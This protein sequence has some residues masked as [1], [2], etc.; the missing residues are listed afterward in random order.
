MG[1]EENY[2]ELAIAIIKQAAKDWR[3]AEKAS[4]KKSEKQGCCR[5]EGRNRA[6]LPIGVLLRTW[7]SRWQ[8][9]FEK[10][11]GGH[12]M[13]TK[14]YLQQAYRL[15][16]R[17]NSHIKELEEL[18]SMAA[19]ISSPQITSDKVQTTPSGDPPY[20]SALMRI[21]EMEEKINA[22]IDL[23]V[24]L[25]AQIH[26]VLKQVSDPDYLMVLRYRYIPNYCWE[27]I[28]EEL[29]ADRRT[30][31]RWHDAAI[32]QLQ[33]PE[34]RSSSEDATVC[35]KM[36]LCFSDIVIISKTG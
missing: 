17:I 8:V 19:A 24:D 12:V 26:T 25:K 5:D 4:E 28:G 9:H 11:E 10:T 6:F 15:D 31:I 32:K 34:K 3:E 23:Y 7:R 29:L 2:Q 13:T 14:E 20:V 36:P 18:K 33:V 22:E 16:K 35:H 27:Q 21:W 1:L 30:V